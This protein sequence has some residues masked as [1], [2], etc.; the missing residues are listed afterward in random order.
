VQNH[1]SVKHGV[2]D[3]VNELDKYPL[4]FLQASFTHRVGVKGV[5][6]N[7]TDGCDAIIVAKNK[8]NLGEEDS[9]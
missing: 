9:E 2:I 8:R 3:G 5:N 6:G 4:T 7:M 1:V